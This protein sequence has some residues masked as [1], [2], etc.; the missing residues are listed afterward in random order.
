MQIFVKGLVKIKKEFIH[1]DIFHFN[2]IFFVEIP[3]PSFNSR[4]N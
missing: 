1:N 2:L 4:S 3:Q